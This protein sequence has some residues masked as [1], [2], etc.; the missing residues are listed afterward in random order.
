MQFDNRH[1]E[2]NVSQSMSTLDKLKEKLSL[3]GSAKAA[4][5]EF[6][7]YNAGVFR[8]KDAVNKA[9]ASIEYDVAHRIKNIMKA[10]TI[11]PVM[12]G[13]SE[14]ETQMNAIQ[15]ILSNTQSKGT[16]IDQVNA[17]LDELNTYADKTI[18]NF[19]E[20]TKNIGTFTAA[21]IDLDKSVKAIQ[22]IA[23]LAAM[24]GST[25]QQAST[26]MYQLSQALSSGKVRL[27]DWN[28]V[29][30]AGMGGEVF[31]TALLE[32][33]K[34]HGKAVDH[35]IKDQ[36]LFRDSLQEGWLTADILTETLAK[37][38]DETTD[39]GKRATE[40]A[41]KVKT[42][43]QLWSTLKETAQSGWTQ[44]WEI[45]VG[46]FYESRDLW[47]SLYESIGGFIDKTSKARNDL[48]SAT[49]SSGWDQI[50]AEGIPNAEDYQNAITDVAKAHGIAFDS[51]VEKEGS[52]EAAL[53]SGLKAGKIT[54]KD[55]ITAAEKMIHDIGLLS[56][57]EKKA[58][59]YTDDYVKSLST[60]TKKLKDGSIN[61]DDLTKKMS[62]LSGRELAI[63]SFKNTFAGLGE[64]IKTVGDAFQR[65]FNPNGLITTS[66][67]AEKLYGIL[68]KIHE[69]TKQFKMSFNTEEGRKNLEKLTRTFEGLFAAVDLIATIIAGPFKLAFGILKEL[70]AAFDLNILDVTAKLADYIIVVRDWVKA[71][72]PISKIIAFVVPHIKKFIDKLVNARDTF[73]AWIASLKESDNL[74]RDIVK[75]L[76]N[77]LTNGAKNVVNGIVSLA[78]NLITTFKNLLG[79]HSPSKVFE[80]FGKNCTQGFANGLKTLGESC[81]GI[82]DGVVEWL[83]DTFGADVINKVFAGGI[84]VGLVIFAKKISD[85]IGIISNPIAN[86]GDLIDDF[87]RALKTFNASAKRLSKAAAFEMNTRGL[88]NIAKALAILVA[89]VV[90]LTVVDQSKIWNAFAM[91]GA[92]AALTVALMIL[93]KKLASP[94][95]K[96]SLAVVLKSGSLIALGL[97]ITLIARAII[98][99]S[100]IE[101]S[102]FGKAAAGL[103]SFLVFI[104]GILVVSK[105]LKYGHMELDSISLVLSKLGVAALL[106]GITSKMLSNIEWKEY[107][108]AALGLLIFGGFITG[109]ML[110]SKFLNLSFTNIDGLSLTLTKMGATL[111]LFAIASK[112][113]STIRWKD[114]GTAMVGML[115]LVSF[116]AG[117]MFVSQLLETAEADLDTI[118]KM[119][120]K[121]G[122]TMLLFALATKILSTMS[123]REFEVAGRGMVLLVSLLMSIAIITEFLSD[124]NQMDQLAKFAS[125]LGICMLLL[126]VSM[127]ILATMKWEEFGKATA[128]LAILGAFMV[129]IIASSKLFG[130][131][132]TTFSRFEWILVGIGA[133]ALLLAITMKIL[134]TI[135]WSEFGR[136]VAGL[137]VVSLF[138]SGLMAAT[139]LMKGIGDWK[140]TVAI[141]AGIAGCMLI[142]STCLLILGTMSWEALDRAATGMLLCVTFFAALLLSLYLLKD[143]EKPAWNAM[144]TLGILTGIMAV[145][146]V[147]LLLLQ[148]VNP[149]RAI[150]NAISLT[151]LFGTLIASLHFLKNMKKPAWNSLITVG[152]LTAVMGALAF[153]LYLLRNLNPLQT[154]ATTVSLVV[155][156]ASLIV[157]LNFMKKLRKPAWNSLITIGILTVVMGALGLILWLLKDLKPAQVISVAVSLSVLLA[158]LIAA[159]KLIEKSKGISGKALL[160]LGALVIAMGLLGLILWALKDLDPKQSIGV[161][162]ALGVFAGVLFAMFFAFSVIGK[163]SALIGYA[164]LGLAAIA[165]LIA[166][167]ALILAAFGLLTKIVDISLIQK[168]G[169]L[170]EAVGIAIGKFVGGLVGSIA[171]GVTSSLPEIGSNL[172]A[173]MNNAQD[174]IEGAKNIDASIIGKVASLS[175]AI[176]AITS[177]NLI[178]NLTSFF[179]G[180]KLREWITGESDMQAFGR[181]LSELGAAVVNFSQA[182]DGKVNPAVVE[183][184]ANAANALSKINSNGFRKLKDV[185]EEQIA[186]ARNAGKAIAAFCE[187]AGGIADGVALSAAEI[188]AAFAKVNIKKFGK[189]L[190]SFCENINGIS[191]EDITFSNNAG[192]V[193]KAV[194]EAVQP[195]NES[196][197]T[198]EDIASIIKSL[199]KAGLK[200]FG[201]HVKSFC[202][203]VAGI[204]SDHVLAASNAG[205]VVKAICDAL[206]PVSEGDIS[207]DTMG[208]IIKSLSK[209]GLKKFGKQLKKF[210]E[211]VEDINSD[212]VLA[213]SNAGKVIKAICD[214]LPT[215]GGLNEFFTGGI[216]MDSFGDGLTH[217]GKNVMKFVK[218]IK[219]LNEESVTKAGYAG[220][221]IASVAA[222]L[223][224]A[225][226][227]LQVIMGE[228]NIEIF[229]DNLD[230][231]GKGVKKFVNKVKN[232][233]ESSVEK[234]G[235]ASSVI[236]KVAAGLPETKGV[237]QFLFGE[238]NIEAFAN[239]LNGLGKG[240]KK[241]IKH[242]SGLDETSVAKAETA[243]KIIS[244]VGKSLPKT[245]GAWQLLF[246]DGNIEVFAA[247]LKGLGKGVKKFVD[248]IGRI[249]DNASTNVT[250]MAAMITSLNEALPVGTEPSGLLT[251]NINLKA[252]GEQL[253]AFGASLGK[254]TTLDDDAKTKIT[255]LLSI[256]Q[257]INEAL[258]AGGKLSGLLTGNLDLKA[259]GDNLV[260][261]VKSLKKF[262]KEAKNLNSKH[263]SNFKDSLETLAESG[264]NGF[265]NKFKNAV[266]GVKEAVTFMVGNSVAGAKNEEQYNKF[267]A[268]GE[269]V[270]SGFNAGITS[271]AS[272]QKAYNAGWKLGSRARQ[273]AEDA[274][275]ENSPSKVFY[276]IGEY[277]GE[278]LVLALND[279]SSKSYD[280][281]AAVATSAADGLTNAIQQV[282]NAV[283][284]DL[285]NTLTIR[286]VLD[287]TSVESGVKTMNGMF[288]MQPSVGVLSNVNAINSS[289]NRRQNASNSDVVDAINTLA[290]HIDNGKVGDTFNINGIT[291][292]GDSELAAAMETI[293]RA[294]RIER[295]T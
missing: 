277:A 225:G 151:L 73:K 262:A 207:P 280:A 178:D 52:F 257:Q 255:S 84:A 236:S 246:G 127:K 121:I 213:A 281:G 259:A 216:D 267:F 200:K 235:Y 278:G 164:M 295:R 50:V 272:L 6:A 4:Q 65:V 103:G 53:R 25:S 10:F 66:T 94:D 258:P 276:G 128:G 219:N 162:V 30:N 211:S 108:K 75:G 241:F 142:L 256:I 78:N 71:H 97:M 273:G 112:I 187:G 212:D 288:S 44:T 27:Q 64:I 70:L 290:N 7:S 129:G 41:T 149:G 156:F 76:L 179:S 135:K 111:V 221:I 199:S 180:G 130:N 88:L 67:L 265:V 168:G 223:P 60:F 172:S 9:W 45:L 21:G 175:G 49:F 33:A 269:Y 171:A 283:D 198:A 191:E 116:V 123:W 233:D 158:C 124:S 14:Y 113:L 150:V 48:L 237:W 74:G 247:N 61:V 204:T 208:S 39:L 82:L 252:G 173:F 186:G 92:L 72:N 55:L 101:W 146:A 85:S 59:G 1:F 16:T 289:M 196:D 291:Y 220:K 251:G 98:K 56:D 206:K 141:F 229:G 93:L 24:S 62:R 218:D 109:L 292:S 210:C 201:K 143:M 232:L 147:L 194:C 152:I 89:C 42:A 5:S 133:C 2:K 99:L 231:L 163:A 26:A 274:L 19:T 154:L 250:N 69:K 217:I 15:T 286:P 167:A 117:L 271:F 215:T 190:K 105:V 20:M 119:M 287:L 195:V 230:L 153:I 134:A 63:E 37:F 132:E 285:D 104:L 176:I 83:K 23:N 260:A 102:D 183:A 159:F 81:K 266:E 234:A 139:K 18:Y 3:K 43:T 170:L 248:Q 253:A 240:V 282:T 243:G 38:T 79:I 87:D 245:D 118:A 242:V 202:E 29:V 284:S 254:I 138:M 174:F 209:A 110:A 115:L 17:A 28:S 95:F 214:N 177:G 125:K 131:A 91:I 120:V 222:G 227:A 263:I 86:F 197:M 140:E 107:G 275:D 155:L 166:E 244:Q 12:T 264:I 100:S 228:S 294:A 126:A 106:F 51:M 160:S 189:H 169:D 68:I 185:A 13:F 157:A 54:S 184:A 205:S 77:G 238:A 136:A 137:A 144:I 40:A 148:N 145:M 293:I 46:D 32:T 239:N 161:A 35:I 181:K 57:E 47:S 226:G 193:V 270:A 261:F 96:E 203:N 188:I 36:G 224:N 122:A 182:V 31:R 279:Y 192:K 34:A 11:E 114:F 22:G 165:L 268:A 249:D 8:W 90:A 80:G 58:K